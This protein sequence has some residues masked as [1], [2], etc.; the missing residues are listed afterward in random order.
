MTG[1]LFI[2]ISLGSLLLFILW[3]MWGNRRSA[4]KRRARAA[5]GFIPGGSAYEV[6][7]FVLAAVFVACGAL[8]LVSPEL[9][10]SGQHAYLFSI[11][12]SYV[13][14]FAPSF[15]F[16]GTAAGIFTMGITVRKRRLG[17][18]RCDHAD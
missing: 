14:S 5:E 4:L 7:L 2:F 8:V 17:Q 12:I 3:E 6:G 18:T 11:L 13:G 1:D 16:V 9:V 15:V 10:T